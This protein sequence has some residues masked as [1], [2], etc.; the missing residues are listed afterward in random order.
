MNKS[1]R[2][3]NRRHKL[4]KEFEDRGLVIVPAQTMEPL[5]ELRDTIFTEAKGL[6]GVEDSD[7]EGFFNN[8][9][10]H[11]LTSTALNNFRMDLISRVNE[12]VDVGALI[13]SSVRDT[14]TDLFG[15]DIAAQKSINI[16]IHQPDD[17]NIPPI[18]RDGD[19]TSNFGTVV[20]VPLVHCF[21]TKGVTILDRKNS[22][23]GTE[24]FLSDE[25]GSEAELDRFTAR[26]WESVDMKFGQVLIFWGPLLHD[27]PINTEGQTRWTLNHRYKNVFSPYD[28]HGIPDYYRILEL[29]PL[30]R[31]GLELE[32]ERFA[33]ELS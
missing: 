28:L 22:Q 19:L 13:F 30:S 29:S 21:G 33:K 25:E 23:R 14:M 17:K 24:L 2:K 15:P 26:H 4:F 1:T 3:T 10:K 12:K 20:W 18:H 16:V 5:E 9:H 11:E 31:L 32:K 27:V 7:V 8:F 6:L